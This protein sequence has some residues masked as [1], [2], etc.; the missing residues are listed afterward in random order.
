MGV[1][2]DNQASIDRHLGCLQSSAVANNVAMNNL[3]HVLF[4]C[5]SLFSV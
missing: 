4:I 2:L 3:M 1:Q 5:G